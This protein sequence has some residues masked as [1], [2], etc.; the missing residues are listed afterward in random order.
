MSLSTTARSLHIAA[1]YTY[2]AGRATRR[3]WDAHSMTPRTLQAALNTANAVIHLCIFIHWLLNESDWSTDIKSIRIKTMKTTA[4][5][6]LTP[7]IEDIEAQLNEVYAQ[8]SDDL[9][10][11]FDS[12]PDPIINAIEAPLDSEL[13]SASLPSLSW[14]K[15]DLVQACRNYGL[16]PTGA[17]TVLVERLLHQLA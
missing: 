2:H 12:Y 5:P 17:K 10:Q 8:I 1:V 9:N 13:S 11:E 4:T 14:T 6:D 7:T 16:K 15:A 3:V